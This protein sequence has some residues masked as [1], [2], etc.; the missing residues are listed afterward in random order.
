MVG[1]L[2]NVFCK[3]KHVPFLKEMEISLTRT[4]FLGVWVKYFSYY[5]LNS[6]LLKYLLLYI[7]FNFRE[8]KVLLVLVLKFMVL[9]FVVLT[10]TLLHMMNI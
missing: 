1:L 7:F 3:R 2:L 9:Q 8:I 5:L 10:V 6:D 4:G